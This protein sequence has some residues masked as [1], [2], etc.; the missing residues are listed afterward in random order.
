M[1]LLNR[2][3]RKTQEG[4]AAVL[5]KG[6]SEE[7]QLI[8]RPYYMLNTLVGFSHTILVSPVCFISHTDENEAPR[9]R[10]LSRVTVSPPPESVSP[11]ADS[12]TMSQQH[13]LR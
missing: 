12:K 4:L 13:F 5:M 10:H 6:I 2:V 11:H 1:P 8:R 7:Q 3:T 9:G